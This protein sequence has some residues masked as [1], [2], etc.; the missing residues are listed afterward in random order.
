VDTAFDFACVTASRSDGFFWGASF[1]GISAILCCLLA[2][3]RGRSGLWWFFIGGFLPWV[4]LAILYVLDDLSVPHPVGAMPPGMVPGDP[5]AA[6]PAPDPGR[7][8]STSD[9][10]LALPQDGWF[11]ALRRQPMGPVS[12]QYLRGAIEM[13]S[14]GKDVPVWCSAFR[15]WV[16]PARVPGFFG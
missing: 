11:Y 1:S 2:P 8:P 5:G 4:S 9:A 15:D 13:G 10:A 6:H 7:W 16:T 14:L 12:L 3:Q